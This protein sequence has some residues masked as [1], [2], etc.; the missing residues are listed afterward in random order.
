MEE[1]NCELNVCLLRC[2]I[3]A[4]NENDHQTLHEMGLNANLIERAKKMNADVFIRLS[5]FNIADITFNSHRFGLML[6]FVE[7]ERLMNDLINKMI[8]QGASQ[9]MLESL[10]GIDPREYRDRR[11]TL[12]LAPASQGRPQNLDAKQTDKLY[13][14]L[15]KHP[16]PDPDNVSTNDLLN[17]YCLIGEKTGL[18]LT[19][20]WHQNMKFG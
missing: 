5:K 18:S 11:R 12:G 10:T 14:V 7:H 13:E 20:I 1:P 17:W 3:N 19:K 9:S 8:I 4:S 16:E 15:S 6:D 2:V